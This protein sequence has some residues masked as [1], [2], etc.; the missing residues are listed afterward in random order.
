MSGVR[1][2]VRRSVPQPGH[3]GLT[4]TR[5]RDLVAELRQVGASE[6]R[7][8]PTLRRAIDEPEAEQE[9]LVHVLDGLDLLGQDRGECRDPDRTRGELLDDRGEELPVR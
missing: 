3:P 7:R 5:R 2:V 4:A 6:I 1:W 9:R 8:D